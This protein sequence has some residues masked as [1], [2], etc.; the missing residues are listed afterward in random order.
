[1]SRTVMESKANWQVLSL[2]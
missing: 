2:F 1:M